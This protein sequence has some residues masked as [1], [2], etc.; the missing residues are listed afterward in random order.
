M[1]ILTSVLWRTIVLTTFINRTNSSG[2]YALREINSSNN[3][4]DILY[5]VPYGAF[6]ATFAYAYYKTDTIYTSMLFHIIQ[7]RPWAKKK[8]FH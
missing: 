5:I 2:K 3:I 6:G 1:N 4:V 8:S 7:P